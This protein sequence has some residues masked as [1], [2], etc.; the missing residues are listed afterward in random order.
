MYVITFFLN[1]E[2]G[3]DEDVK[4]MLQSRCWRK[5]KMASACLLEFM[6]FSKSVDCD[7]ILDRKLS[8]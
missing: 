7:F 5:T 2:D 4:M 8:S 1:R 6:N 3:E